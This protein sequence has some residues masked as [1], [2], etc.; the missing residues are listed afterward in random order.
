[1]F[2]EEYL[3]LEVKAIK[4]KREKKIQA[5]KAVDAATHGWWL[6]VVFRF[7]VQYLIFSTLETV[8]M[9]ATI[10]VCGRRWKYL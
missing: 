8:A 4:K 9:F 7:L 5:A 6:E 10:V 2:A 3:Q 1:M